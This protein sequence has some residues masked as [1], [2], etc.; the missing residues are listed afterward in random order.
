MRHWLPVLV[1]VS[2]V[3]CNSSGPTTPDPTP[4]PTPQPNRAPVVT[5]VLATPTF[6]IQ[7]FGIFTFNASATDA[8][9]D[10]LTFAWNIAGNARTGAVVQAGPFT[11]GGT[12]QATVTV[13]DGR[14]GSTAGSVQFIVGTMTGTWS[15]AVL[16]S[17][18]LPAFTMVLNQA[19]GLFTGTIATGQGNGQVGPTG[20]IATITA[21]GAITMRIKVAPFSDFTMTGQMDGTGRNVT[22]TVSGSGFTGEPFVMSKS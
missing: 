19:L 9:G 2:L 7:D 17:N 21:S 15:G 4:T 8:D 10:A 12:G 6:G 13:T 11:N 1:L 5:S 3:A 18:A 14:G 20:A 16:Q 22:G